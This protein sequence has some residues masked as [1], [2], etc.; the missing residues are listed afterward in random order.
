MRRK[1][2]FTADPLQALPRNATPAE[3]KEEVARHA[4]VALHKTTIAANGSW[5]FVLI[6]APIAGQSLASI[7][8]RNGGIVLTGVARGKP[9]QPALSLIF[10]FS[11][12]LPPTASTLPKPRTP[13]LPAKDSG[14]SG[15][16]GWEEFAEREEFAG[17]RDPV[18]PPYNRYTFAALSARKSL[19]IRS[20]KPFAGKALRSLKRPLRSD[21]YGN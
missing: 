5:R 2:Q 7:N 1:D 9:V 4:R 14:A 10:P 18:L 11:T 13:S 15:L 8:G 19:R 21:R 6:I 20:T 16:R 17:R 3:E 12:A